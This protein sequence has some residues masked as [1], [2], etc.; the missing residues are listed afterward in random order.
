MADVGTPLVELVWRALLLILAGYVTYRFDRR[1]REEAKH[2]RRL[3]E[4]LDQAEQN[5]RVLQGEESAV[6]RGIV[7]IVE[8][9]DEELDN[10]DQRLTS[11]REEREEIQDR[12]D[13]MKGRIR[14]RNG[15][16]D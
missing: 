4:A 7:E 14:E 9:H 8:L 2:E 13:A 3:Q 10:H 12:L 11:A 6:G 5:D 16:E 1:T 15:S